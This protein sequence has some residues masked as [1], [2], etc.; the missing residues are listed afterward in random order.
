MLLKG[1]YAERNLWLGRWT[2]NKMM[3][4]KDAPREEKVSSSYEYY[5]IGLETFLKI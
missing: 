1:V 5:Y 4:M 2:A 3:S